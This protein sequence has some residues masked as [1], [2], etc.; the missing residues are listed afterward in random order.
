[1]PKGRSQD[2]WQSHIVHCLDPCTTD[3][4]PVKYQYALIITPAYIHA[5]FQISS[6]ITRNI[7]MQIL[8][9]RIRSFVFMGFIAFSVFAEVR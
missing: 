7:R 4:I 8:T 1:M 5:G 3:D 9:L 6:D 2:C